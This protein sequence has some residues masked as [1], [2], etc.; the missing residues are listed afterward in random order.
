MKVK[1]AKL[2]GIFVLIFFAFRFLLPL[3]LPFVL[4]Y[5]FAKM[6][7]PIINFLE[8]RLH[9]R[10]RVTVLMIVLITFLILAGFA[11]YIISLAIS[12]GILLLQKIP[13]YQQMI[14]HSLQQMCHHCD[15][16]LEL[17]GGTSYQYVENQM[18]NLYQ[19]IG[20]EILPRVSQ[21][22]TQIF[23]YIIKASSAIF[24]FIISAILILFDDTFP[25]IRG[26]IRPFAG[27]LRK[28]GLL[29]IKSQMIIFFIIAAI[30][31]F[32]LFLMGNQYA[33]I[34][35]VGIAVFDAFPVVGSGIVLIPWALL[36]IISGNYYAAA[37]LISLFAIAAFLREILEPK[38]FGKELDLKPLYILISVYVG[39]KLL[40]LGGVLLGPIGL[41]V[42]KVADEELQE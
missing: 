35:G 3:F 15:R 1:Y 17:S 38:L 4:A 10:H 2:A 9:W 8:E 13:V 36:Q 14:N 29:Y 42:L 16:V 5:F 11:A 12:Q 21:C 40:G 25:K 22:V 27:R 34:L 19:T 20:K 37:I 39:A 6:I 41:T 24:I 18:Q 7:S 32:G 26:R 30:N 23:H 33:I 28:A 31:S